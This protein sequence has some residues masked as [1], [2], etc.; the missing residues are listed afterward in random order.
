MELASFQKA[1]ALS[2]EHT[3]NSSLSD[4]DYTRLVSKC[5]QP[6]VECNLSPPSVD[7][8][9]WISSMVECNLFNH[10]QSNWVYNRGPQA[11]YYGFVCV[12]LSLSLSLHRPLQEFGHVA[13]VS[14][15][16]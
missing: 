15:R 13:K 12:S 5:L 2:T 4:N 8:A 11:A 7:E 3:Q 14:L 9:K 1:K 10:L 6:E 16:F